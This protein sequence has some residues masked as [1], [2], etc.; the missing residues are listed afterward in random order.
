MLYALRAPLAI[1]HLEVSPTS[2]QGGTSAT[3]TAT[4]NGLAPAGGAVV[5]LLSSNSS[6]AQV[7][8]TVTVPQGLGAAIFTITTSTVQTTTN[9][10]IS[11]SHGGQQRQATLEVRSA[12]GGW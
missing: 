11:G 2:V 7:P 3:G 9:V 12:G 6:A 10:T 4:L 8:A 1:A 5:S